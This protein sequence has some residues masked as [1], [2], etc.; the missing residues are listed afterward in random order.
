MGIHTTQLTHIRQTSGH[1]LEH[2]RDQVASNKSSESQRA[3]ENLS[4]DTSQEE[5]AF[6]LFL[7]VRS[8][9]VRH[10]V[11]IQPNYGPRTCGLSATLS[12]SLT[13]DY[14]S[15]IVPLGACA[16]Q[17]S[18]GPWPPNSPCLPPSRIALFPVVLSTRILGV[19][20]LPATMAPCSSVAC[21]LGRIHLHP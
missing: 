7:S 9:N 18:H 15:A 2:K 10:P 3:G 4:D 8:V 6:W 16:P 12:S 14:G 17:A 20:G 13:C 5:E 19:S 1:I 21:P 11:E